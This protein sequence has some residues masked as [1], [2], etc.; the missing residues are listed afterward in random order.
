MSTKL[1][2][3]W[4]GVLYALVGIAGLG[5]LLFADAVQRIPFFRNQTIVIIVG[6]LFTFLFVVG[7]VMA[8][9]KRD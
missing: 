9:R 3:R 2:M 8:I 6:L 4:I 5:A 1:L 7:L